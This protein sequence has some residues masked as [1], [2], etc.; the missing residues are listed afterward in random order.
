MDAAL[1]LAEP[2]SGQAREARASSPTLVLPG[3]G[4]QGICIKYDEIIR[5]GNEGVY[6]QSSTVCA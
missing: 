6:F 4:S 1:L 5:E 2:R 3:E